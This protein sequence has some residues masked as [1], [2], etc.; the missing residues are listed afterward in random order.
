MDVLPLTILALAA[1][2]VGLAVARAWVLLR[3]VDAPDLTLR[4][5]AATTA[6]GELAER[7]QM[8]LQL[9]DSTQL[10]FE[11]DK[12]SEE[13]RDRTLRALKREAVVV[14]KKMQ[15][16]GGTEQDME[17][18]DRELDAYVADLIERAALPTME[19]HA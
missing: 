13:D 14:M 6:H 12:I 4:E 10:D 11:T 7:K 17:R 3:N 16:L 15:E 19:V 5:D 2:A 18:A 8:L 1:A 9:M